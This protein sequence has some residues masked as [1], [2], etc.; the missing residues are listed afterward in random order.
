MDPEDRVIK[1]PGIFRK[2]EAVLFRRELICCPE[3][4]RQ[5]SSRFPALSGWLS[6]VLNKSSLEPHATPLPHTVPRILLTS[7][8]PCV[9]QSP[10]KDMHMCKR[11]SVQTVF[12]S[13]QTLHHFKV[14]CR[15]GPREKAAQLPGDFLG[16]IRLLNLTSSTLHLHTHN[17]FFLLSVLTI[18][19]SSVSGLLSTTLR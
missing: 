8:L 5:L 2:Q 13:V 18:S 4:R 19:Q 9:H 16:K 10:P 12:R 3:S 1:S 7:H 14:T 15:G 11:R 6:S 17:K